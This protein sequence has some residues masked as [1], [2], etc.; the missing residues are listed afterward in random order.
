MRHRKRVWKDQALAKIM[1]QV[2]SQL[3][4]LVILQTRLFFLVKFLFRISFISRKFMRNNDRRV[5][6]F[7]FHF[8]VFCFIKHRISFFKPLRINLVIVFCRS[9]IRSIYGK[10]FPLQE[11]ISKNANVVLYLGYL[12]HRGPDPHYILS[13]TLL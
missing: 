1:G 5:L 8:L 2:K 10:Y 4:I 3:S 9:I 6:I 7:G 11:G 12:S 13:S